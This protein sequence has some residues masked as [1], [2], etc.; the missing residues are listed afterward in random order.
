MVSLD[1][2]VLDSLT[3]LP[4]AEMT[5]ELNQLGAEGWQLATVGTLQQNKR[6]LTFV[7]RS[8]AEYLVLDY[9]TGKSPDEVEQLF[10]SYGADGWLLISVDQ[11]DQRT[12]RV[13]MMRT[14]D[15]GGNGGT[16]IGEAPVD[17]QTYGRIDSHWET[18]INHNN[19]FVDGGNF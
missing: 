3:G 15:S 14:Q 4:S 2:H 17:G 19:D 13:I 8:L 11:L 1:Y 12:R 5:D 10:D 9:P 18:V 7:Q 16:G 6:R